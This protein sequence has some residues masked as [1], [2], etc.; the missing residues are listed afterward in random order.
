MSTHSIVSRQQWLATHAE[1]LVK[2]KHVTRQ[3]EALAAARRELPW[4]RLDKVY[5]FQDAHGP[6]GL[7]D[8]FEGR[9]Q[10][11]VKHFM[12]GPDWQ[13]GCVGCSFEMDHLQGTLV[14]LANHDVSVVA[15]SRAPFAALDAFRQRMG[16]QIRWVSSAGSDF[17]RDFNVSFD[18]EDVIDGKVFYNFTWTPFVCEELSG[19]SVFHRDETGCIFHT[20]S[21]YGRGAEELLGSYV[22]LDMTPMGRNENGPRRDLTDWVRHHDRYG[23]G[24]SVDVTGRARPG[25]PAQ[26]SDCC[27]QAAPTPAS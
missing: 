3:R 22:L 27:H 16:W 23:S 1:H 2:E 8:L 9:S 18:P 11:I 7:D 14:H 13:E 5:R 24:D 20:F 25:Q 21:A 15:V 26:S 10:L 19:F 4:A 17:N 12:F 6:V